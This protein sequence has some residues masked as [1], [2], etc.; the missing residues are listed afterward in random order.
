MGASDS[1]FKARRWNFGE[2][3]AADM[4]AWESSHYV[5]NHVVHEPERPPHRLL[6]RLIDTNRLFGGFHTGDEL[7]ERLEIYKATGWLYHPN[8]PVPT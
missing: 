1:R 3:Q 6:R 8:V 2:Q 7:S 4:L 5:H